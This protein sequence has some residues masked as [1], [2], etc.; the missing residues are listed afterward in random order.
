MRTD[1]EPAA[2]WV[3]IDSM[4]P[5][6]K[7]P[8]D[9]A[10]AVAKVAQQ[11]LDRQESHRRAG[12]N[13]AGHPAARLVVPGSSIRPLSQHLEAMRR[14]GFDGRKNAVAVLARHLIQKEVAH[15]VGE[16]Q[17][18]LGVELMSISSVSEIVDLLTADNP[19]A[20]LGDVTMY[21]HAWLLYRQALRA[22]ARDGAVYVNHKTGARAQ[23]PSLQVQ[24]TQT[25]VM[26]SQRRV[27]KTDRLWSEE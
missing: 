6:E 1:R 26:Q 12:P 22:V 25:R 5:W 17:R 11:R 27:A 14:V 3:R 9:N 18:R 21:A 13:I 23:N 2:E 15:R 19:N 24:A 16:N 7:N 20:P 10:K 4:K 8:R